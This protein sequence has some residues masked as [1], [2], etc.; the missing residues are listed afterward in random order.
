[1]YIDIYIFQDIYV[2]RISVLIVIFLIFINKNSM[3][4]KINFRSILFYTISKYFILMYICSVFRN[5]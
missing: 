2:I 1:M 4:R 5:F 3:I